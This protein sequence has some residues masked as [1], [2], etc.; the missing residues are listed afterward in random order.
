MAEVI[1]ST[2]NALGELVTKSEASSLV[3]DPGGFAQ[4]GYERLRVRIIG[5]LHQR[6]N[7][8]LAILAL[9]PREHRPRGVPPRH[10]CQ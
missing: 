6:R 7:A 4:I 1:Y 8:Q 5:V 9:P 2:W 10:G 3:R